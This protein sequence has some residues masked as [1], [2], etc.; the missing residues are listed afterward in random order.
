M[1]SALPSL[2]SK[3]SSKK[4]WVWVGIVAVLAVA[5]VGWS[6]RGANRTALPGAP[7]PLPT[8]DGK[9]M[10]LA[11]L[12]GKPTMLA[13]WAPWCGYCKQAVSTISKVAELAGSHAQVV[14]VALSYD[15]RA[16]VEKFTKDNHVDY[17]V[18]LGDNATAQAFGVDS[19]PTFYFVAS[20]GRVSQKV[21]GALPTAGLL[22]QL[23]WAG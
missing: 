9:E 10:T 2:G 7:A 18:L 16:A 19:F 14:S 11:S 1:E 3:P 20:D 23:F 13:F 21:V 5:F 12:Q 6:L 15:D 17:P 4:Q 8:L 22:W